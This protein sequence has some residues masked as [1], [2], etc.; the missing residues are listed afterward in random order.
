MS[1]FDHIIGVLSNVPNR[2]VFQL[3]SVV[4]V[5]QHQTAAHILRRESCPQIL[6]KN[7]NTESKNNFLLY[8]TSEINL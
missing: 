5:C 2:V 4:H 6:N 1:Y 3:G 8:K 7:I